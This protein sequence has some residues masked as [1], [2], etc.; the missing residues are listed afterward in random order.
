MKVK[1]ICSHYMLIIY[2]YK[3]IDNSLS[4]IS[5]NKINNTRINTCVC[6][7]LIVALPF[8]DILEEYICN[9]F[10]LI[11]NK[12]NSLN[13]NYNE[14]GEFFFV[15]SHCVSMVPWLHNGNF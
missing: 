6:K 3:C 4:S 15:V 12:K 8:Q 14:G 1:T 11:I 7:H 13:F 2:L 10:T 5:A 9:Y